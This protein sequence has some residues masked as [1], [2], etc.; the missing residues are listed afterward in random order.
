[1]NNNV[2]PGFVYKDYHVSIKKKPLNNE[3]LKSKE[4]KN[5]EIKK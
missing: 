1:M 5:K 2:K 4:E 3:A